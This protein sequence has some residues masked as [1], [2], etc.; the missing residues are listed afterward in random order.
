MEHIFVCYSRKDQNFTLQLKQALEKV[1]KN[2]W[3]DV[4]DLPA[5]YI[6]RNEIKNAITEAIAFV[7]LVSA[8]SLGS[9]YCQKEF[10]FARQ[11]NK[12]I[13][14]ILLPETTDK[15]IPEDISSYQWLK[16][17]DFGK[18]LNITKLITDIETD[19]RW[20]RFITELGVKA[21][22][23]EEHADISRL[24]RGKALQEVEQLLA[25]VGDQK[26]PQPTS[27]QR[28]YVLASRKEEERRRTRAV[29]ISIIASVVMIALGIYAQIQGISATKQAATAQAASTGEAKQ[30]A[31]AQ[32]AS[33]LAIEQRII[34]DDQ[35]DIA[36]SRQLAA[37]SEELRTRDPNSLPLSILLSVESLRTAHTVE[38]MQ[39]LFNGLSV[40]A[41][42]VKEAQVIPSEEGVSN[43]ITNI[44]ISPNGQKAAMVAGNSVISVWDINEWKEMMRIAPATSP[45][46]ASVVRSISFCSKKDL[47]ISG[48]DSGF[49]QVWDLTSGDE[50]SR[51][52]YDDQVFITACAPNNNWVISGT[53]QFGTSGTLEVWDIESKQQIYALDVE[54]SINMIST[55]SDGSIAAV[56]GNKR[57]TVWDVQSGKILANIIDP[58]NTEPYSIKGITTLAL[59]Q[60]GK[61]VASGDGYAWGTST[62]SRT[63]I[64]GNIF[65]WE[66]ATGKKVLQVNQT[67]EI[68]DL[69]FSPDGTR[70][71]SG[72]Y[73]GFAMVWNISNGQKK[74]E[75][76]Y[77]MPVTAVAFTNMGRWAMASGGNGI[78]QIWEVVNGWVV[79]QLVSEKKINLT[80]MVVTSDGHFAI[81]G[82]D[83][84]DV[85]VWELIEQEYFFVDNNEPIAS[86]AFSPTGE[87]L[88]T[89]GWDDKTRIWDSVTGQLVGLI[90]HDEKVVSVVISP[91]GSYGA[92]ASVDGIVR[93]WNPE[94]GVL[95]GQPP[96]LRNVGTIAFSPD[97]KFLAIAEGIF[98]RDGW[99]I[100]KSGVEETATASVIIWDLSKMEVYK[101]LY[102]L[103]W[104]NSLAFDNTG[105][106]LITG[107]NNKKAIV[108]DIRTGKEVSHITHNERVN[109][110][111]FSPDGKWATSVE[112]CFPSTTCKPILKMWNPLDGDE[113]WSVVL[114]GNWVSGL[115]FSPDSKFLLIANNFVSCTGNNSECG[116]GTVY[117]WNTN[118]GQLVRRKP[119]DGLVIT[120]SFSPDNAYVASGGGSAIGDSAKG[121]L[122]IWEPSTGDTVLSIPFEEPWSATFSPDN[123]HIAVGG[124][125]TIPVQLIDL[126]FDNLVDVACSRLNRNFSYEEWEQYFGKST[127]KPTCPNLPS[128]V[129]NPNGDSGN[130]SLSASGKYV[131]FSSGASNIVCTDFNY[132]SDVFLFDR[133]TKEATLLSKTKKGALGNGDSFS[134][135]I[136]SDGR[137]IVFT[138]DAKNLEEGT[139]GFSQ[140][141][142]YDRNTDTLTLISKDATSKPGNDNSWSPSMSADGNQI[143]F[144]SSA[145][146]L[147]E[148]ESNGKDQIYLFDRISEQI[149][150]VSVT[151]DGALADDDAFSP[152]ISADGQS[153]LFQSYA[154]NF[155]K[156]G[157]DY[158]PAFI[159]ERRI[160]F[161]TP[162]ILDMGLISYPISHFFTENF[163]DLQLSPD[164]QFVTGIVVLEGEGALNEWFFD[165][166]FLLD[167]K[168]G[169]FRI[170]SNSPDGS[171]GNK[172]SASP[173]ISAD[174]RFIVFSSEATNLV[175]NDTNDAWDIFVYD[176]ERGAIRR[177][178][179]RT[180]G[181][182]ANGNSHYPSI[183]SGGRY[184]TFLSLASNLADDDTNGFL[185]VFL[186]DTETGEILRVVPKEICK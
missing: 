163:Y 113:K 185:D 64:G 91:N 10:E 154:R 143:V 171:F 13:F 133:D 117:V 55:N 33:T 26:D 156:D 123:K 60:D 51:R 76:N 155:V 20:V 168:S 140:I 177:V 16:W 52:E 43:D 22:Q 100:Y 147:S 31:T 18:E 1:G 74:S 110:V 48:T 17:D 49:V 125:G 131:A 179:V 8:N 119:H 72:S 186:V 128:A 28:Q 24:L 104:V 141:F 98:P 161:A 85:R 29:A 115:V 42:I 81:A 153:V 47:L 35:R 45:G 73:D 94:N 21:S 144:V 12:R 114:P 130:T 84:G 3:I 70:L 148:A 39:S 146:N 30:A 180:D 182:Q 34:A 121:K 4:E 9:E 183:S 95:I 79:K 97:N 166:I 58:L 172:D 164:G 142:L 63:P 169:E 112:A 181:V 36:L 77:G 57:I 75:L 162:L 11:L 80:T 83:Q 122:L 96:K 138:S 184:I 87:K 19:Y 66:V 44:T 50:I 90:Q 118:N 69:E 88:F 65:V 103:G 2:V 127:Y 126:N 7:Y 167:R 150:I 15:E 27:L 105:N 59:S 158:S 165:E 46:I 92:S 134:T 32:S 61:Y 108:W 116:R 157:S 23:W 176:L 149:S 170:V 175:S 89:G 40:F 25:E 6:W 145:T 152:S 14:P 137:Y 93:I 178:S 37:Q 38:G 132:S 71:L 62:V 5:S 124:H 135:S 54:A 99:F 160:G 159:Y 173:K 82:D 109:L 101:R 129:V 139:D 106:F 56:A 111:A 67:D 86:V 120:L 174:S 68:L 41:P 78:I 102:H 53:H 151:P 136:S 107:G